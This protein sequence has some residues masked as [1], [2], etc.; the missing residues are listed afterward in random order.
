MCGRTCLHGLG[1][2]IAG[3]CEDATKVVTVVRAFGIH[4]G[5][6]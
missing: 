1:Q 2:V 4:F 3:D 5:R 6:T